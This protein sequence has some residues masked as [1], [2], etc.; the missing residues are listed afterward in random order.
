MF[1]LKGRYDGIESK[2]KDLEAT[3]QALRGQMKSLI[4]PYQISLQNIEMIG[5]LTKK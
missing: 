4:D 2:R 5:K 1:E 3:L